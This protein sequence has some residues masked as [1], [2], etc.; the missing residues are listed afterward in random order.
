METETVAV[1]N[2]TRNTVL[3]KKIT[4]AGTSLGAW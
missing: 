3:G 1:L 4:V 2:T